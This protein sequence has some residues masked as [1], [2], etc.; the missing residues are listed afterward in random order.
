MRRRRRRRRRRGTSFE[1]PEGHF[2]PQKAQNS[3][4][5]LYAKCLNS[6]VFYSFFSI[7]GGLWERHQNIEN[8]KKALVL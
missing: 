5:C 4:I 3:P 2:G 7:F 6:I 8:V 1:H